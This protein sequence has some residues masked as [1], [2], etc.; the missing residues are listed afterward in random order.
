M[1]TIFIASFPIEILS[2]K[3]K[4]KNMS[5]YIDEILYLV[6]YVFSAKNGYTFKKLPFF[7]C[8]SPW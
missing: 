7:S 4:Y 5:E 1:K 2:Q 8:H 6:Y 3:I